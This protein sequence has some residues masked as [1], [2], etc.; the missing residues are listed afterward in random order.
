MGC[1]NQEYFEFDI[2][3]C[4]N[5]DEIIEACKD[6]EQQIAC[7]MDKCAGNPDPVTE[8]DI[9]EN[10][11]TSSGP[12][13]DDFLEFNN[14]NATDY[15]DCANLGAG[16]SS[17]T[18]EGAWTTTFPTMNS[19]F[20]G[21]GGFSLGYDNSKCFGR[22]RLHMQIGSRLRRQ[23]S[24]PFRHDLGVGWLRTTWSNRSRFLDSFL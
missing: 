18:G 1:D 14:T 12:D 13:K 23:R 16:L 6:V 10:I 20:G 8:I 24:V 4:V 17:S 21:G 22:W 11:T 2:S 5:A 9:I 3:Q 15:G 7:Q 19:I